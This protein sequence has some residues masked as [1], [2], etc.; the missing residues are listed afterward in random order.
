[1]TRVLVADDDP[2]IL[3][4]VA[5]KLRGAGFDVTTVA[6]GDAAVR[7]ARRATPDLV[8]LDVMMPKM[9]GIDVCRELRSSPDTAEVP[10]VLLTARSQERDVERGFDAGANDYLVKPF[11]PRELLS[12]ARALLARPT[13]SGA[14]QGDG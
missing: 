11:S 8:I 4:L 12:R 3:E 6:D 14:G 9:S 5:F 10:I 2:D 7:E 13:G 1:M